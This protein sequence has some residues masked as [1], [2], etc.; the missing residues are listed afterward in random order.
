LLEKWKIHS[1]KDIVYANDTW[2]G[3]VTIAD[4]TN[5]VIKALVPKCRTES[6]ALLPRIAAAARLKLWSHADSIVQGQIHNS[7]TSRTGSKSTATLINCPQEFP[8]EACSWK[9]LSDLEVHSNPIITFRLRYHHNRRRSWCSRGLPSQVR[10][11]RFCTLVLNELRHRTMNVVTIE[12]AEQTHPSEQTHLP[13]RLTTW[14]LMTA[15]CRLQFAALRYS[16]C[17][18]ISIIING[19]VQYHIFALDLAKQWR[20]TVCRQ[21]S[22]SLVWWTGVVLLTVG[23]VYHHTASLLL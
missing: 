18:T 3:K 15:G 7:S 1:N 21:L 10:I 11:S 6:T 23:D 20:E 12:L 22:H 19:A 17:M 16:V 2:Q 8:T 9:R 4:R 5:F 13:I 14:Q